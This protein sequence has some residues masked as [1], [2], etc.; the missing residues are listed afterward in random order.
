M[1]MGVYNQTNRQHFAFRLSLVFPWGYIETFVLKCAHD[2]KLYMMW[3]GVGVGVG[4]YCIERPL[5]GHET[6]MGWHTK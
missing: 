5:L 4:V 1:H 3:G 6:V 2:L